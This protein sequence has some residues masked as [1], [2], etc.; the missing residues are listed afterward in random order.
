VSGDQLLAALRGAGL[1]DETQSIHLARVAADKG[2]PLEDILTTEGGLDD[3][4]I[5]DAKSAVLRVPRYQ[6][7]EKLDEKLL[8]YV[9][10]ETARTYQVVPISSTEGNLVVG[11]V[12]PD[13]LRAQEALKFLARQHRLNLGVFL[14][15]NGDW[16]RAL[17]VYSPFQ[18]DV[19]EAVQSLRVKTTGTTSSQQKVADL[20]GGGSGDDAPIIRVVAR[21][22]K[23]AIQAG[24]S[25]VHIEPGE[26]ALRIRFRIDGELKEAASLPHELS[27]QIISRVKILA[28]MKIDERRVPQDGRFRSK[29]LGKE[30]DFR[31]ATFPTPLGEKVAI[32]ILDPSTGLRTFEELGLT[33]TNL[34]KVIEALNEPFGMVLVTGPTGS[35][36]TTTLYAALS[37][38]NNEKVN[39]VSLEDPVEYFVEGV[40]Q[41]QVRPEIGYDFAAGLRQILRQDPD[42][43]MVGEIRDRETA[44]LAVNA[45]LTGHVVLSTLH[46]NDAAGV[47]PRLIDMG[48]EPFLLPA[49]LNLMVAQRLVGRLCEACR[50]QEDA[51]PA[52]VA[53]IEAQLGAL[54]AGTEKPVAPYK[55]WRSPGCDVCHGRG[56]VGRVAL[57][58]VIKMT[59]EIE[60][61]VTTG[62]SSNAI[63][64]E[65][66]KQGALTMRQDGILKALGGQ[67]LLEEV[68]K[69]TNED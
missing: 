51:S 18:D 11:M 46:T 63:R 42:I 64:D 14:I 66:R 48:V 21:T 20:E 33:G 41:S 22:L 50:I 16:K 39:I 62:A 36:K 10:E 69:E 13:D 23:E 67:V 38:I 52:A 55:V 53:E 28:E 4:K 60:K 8:Q 29:L 3:G 27:D 59:R 30:I 15:S 68:L 26:K 45:A 43:I 1:V 49:A 12:N 9:P 7:P 61:I 47:I 34:Q 24:A 6:M 5:A 56:S 2:L 37:K 65:A 35:G 31:V 57:Y 25:D 17:R 58:E 44:D 32:R 40:N 54:P 19:S